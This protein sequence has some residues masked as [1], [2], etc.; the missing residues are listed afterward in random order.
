M[1]DR[2][3]SVSL[4]PGCSATIEGR[5]LGPDSRQRGPL[6]NHVVGNTSIV[7]MLVAILSARAYASMLAAN[8]DE[9]TTEQQRAGYQC[10]GR[11]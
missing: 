11:P 2:T 1:S 7:P 3:L 9:A 4:N 6:L 10:R 8:R 5:V